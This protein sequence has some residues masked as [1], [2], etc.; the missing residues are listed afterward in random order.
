MPSSDLEPE[1][2][3]I[4]LEE[5]DEVLGNPCLEALGTVHVAAHRVD[6]RDGN[7]ITQKFDNGIWHG[8]GPDGGV[9][10]NSAFQAEPTPQL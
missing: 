6:A 1:I 4:F 9:S 5:A 8:G 2:L 7:Q 10:C 3:Q